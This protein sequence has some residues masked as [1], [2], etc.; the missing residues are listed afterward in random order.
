MGILRATTMHCT[1]DNRTNKHKNLVFYVQ[2]PPGKNELSIQLFI[3]CTPHYQHTMSSEQA[4]FAEQV[5][6]IVVAPIPV[7]DESQYDHKV[8][9]HRAGDVML[10]VHVLTCPTNRGYT[11]VFKVWDRD[12]LN[13]GALDPDVL[14]DNNIWVHVKEAL[15]GPAVPVAGA[16]IL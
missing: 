12:M 16:P 15:H 3:S 9:Q 8:E 5:L 1:Q 4:V 6:N 10:D 2:R 14:D 11:M 7:F 13:R